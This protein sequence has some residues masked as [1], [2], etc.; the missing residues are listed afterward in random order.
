AG[1]RR[2]QPSAERGANRAE[3]E[4]GPAGTENR[5]FR[6]QSLRSNR[7]QIAPRR[8]FPPFSSIVPAARLPHHNVLPASR[9][10]KI[11]RKCPVVQKTGPEP[12]S[13]SLLQFHASAPFR[14]T[15]KTKNY[16]NSLIRHF[17]INQFTLSNLRIFSYAFTH[18]ANPC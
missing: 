10:Q 8:A 17:I 9:R 1:P 16:P 18:P 7:D 6:E 3:S 4:A 12:V 11:P 15:L 5:Q 13:E 2:V 14:S